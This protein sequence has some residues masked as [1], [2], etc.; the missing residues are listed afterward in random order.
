VT[1][2][3]CTHHADRPALA[4]CAGCG[5]PLCSACVVRLSAGNY[6]EACAA[7]PD[8]RPAPPPKARSRLWI[9]VGAAV[10][11]ALILLV[12]RLL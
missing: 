7:A 3:A 4:Y 10:A 12:A 6:C 8:H 9:V 2:I 5:K 1:G 11:V